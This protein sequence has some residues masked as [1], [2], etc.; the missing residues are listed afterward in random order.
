MTGAHT[1]A[2]TSLDDTCLIEVRKITPTLLS[3]SFG[4]AREGAL[5]GTPQ[6]MRRLRD[7]LSVALGDNGVAR[8]AGVYQ[9]AL[10]LVDD[11][12]QHL[13]DDNLADLD[14][15]AVQPCDQ[16]ATTTNDKREAC[17]LGHA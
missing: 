14:A 13:I 15:C 7:R 17:C 3:V 9:G 2:T 5:Y 11:Q 6:V 16:P 8:I 1:S 12:G 4:S 10:V